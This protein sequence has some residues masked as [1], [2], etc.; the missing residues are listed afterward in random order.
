MSYQVF[1]RKYRP[2]TFTDLLGQEHVVQTLRNAIDQ[3]RLANAYLFVGPRGTGKTTTARLLAKA[4]NCPNGPKVDFDPNDPTCREIAEGRSLDVMELDGATHNGVDNVRDIVEQMAFAPTHGKFKIVY[5]DEVHMLSKGAFNALLKSLEEPP[6]HVKFI[7]ATTEGHKVLPTIISRCQRFDLKPIDVPTIAGHLVHVCATEN[8]TITEEAAF[9]VAKGAD[10][11]MRDALSMLDQL[12]SFCGDNITEANVFEI[13]GFTSIEVVA[14]LCQAIFSLETANALE[15][16]HRQ[17][18]TGKDLAQFNNSIISILRELLIARIDPDSPPENLVGE[19]RKTLLNSLELVPQE[20]L[21]R[22]IDIFAELENRMRFANN[23]RL[24][25]EMGAIKAIHALNEASI[26][27]VIK[28][29]GQSAEIIDQRLAK[30]TAKPI[31]ATEPPSSE[32]AQPPTPSPEAPK[33]S[34]KDNPAANS[35]PTNAHQDAPGHHPPQ[36]ATPS[37]PQPPTERPLDD[38]TWNEVTSQVAAERPMLTA[39]L[40]GSKVTAVKDGGATIGLPSNADFAA[41]SLNRTQTR[42][43]IESM[44]AQQTGSTTRLTFQTSA[45]IPAIEDA[46][47]AAEPEP[48]KPVASAASSAPPAAEKTAA[49]PEKD[50]KKKA[51]EQEEFYNDPLITAALEQFRAKI[52]DKS[53]E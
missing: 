36:S 46:L 5:I 30:S 27:D 9:A 12:V 26:N 8:V 31:N 20:R 4:L 15:I 21:L 3:D 53:P 52:T 28:V 42:E 39:W 11:G 14:E 43:F 25:I 44:V 35:I 10:G 24:L 18:E 2:L 41:E 1:A 19:T 38:Q 29:I 40:Q 47:P 48:A 33:P 50:G 45:Q 32:P 13:F 7:F 17:A 16:I 34:S 6:P 51:Q 49:S 37:D 22:L 23:K